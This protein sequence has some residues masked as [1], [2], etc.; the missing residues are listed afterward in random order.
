MADLLSAGSTG[1]RS[2][3]GFLIRVRYMCA[4]EYPAGRQA[5]PDA[6]AA[7]ATFQYRIVNCTE[8]YVNLWLSRM[9]ILICAD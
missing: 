6:L 5:D 9:K 3:R 7:R 8:K 4:G 2:Q 1:G